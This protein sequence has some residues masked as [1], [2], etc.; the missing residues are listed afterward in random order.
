MKPAFLTP[1][2]AV[3]AG[4]SLAAGAH[5]QVLMLD[6][7]PTTTTATGNSPYHA[8][9]PG[10]TGTSWNKVQTSDLGSGLVFAD[11]SAASGVSVN[12]GASTSVTTLDLSGVPS[13]NSALGSTVNTGIYAGTSVGTDGIFTGSTNL[14]GTSVGVQIGGLAAGTYD[15]YIAARNTS[16]ASTSNYSQA[17]AVGVSSVSGNFNYSGYDSRTLSFTNAASPIAT[18]AWADGSN[19]L[20]FSVTLSSDQFL[21]LAVHG[22]GEDMRGFLNAV[23]IVATSSAIPEPSSV[24][25][26]GGAAVLGVAALRRRRN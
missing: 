26:L 19:Y 13:G 4:L 23:Q 10:F 21:N 9:T 22:G 3:A 7:G 5:S 18:S 25:V 20:K 1:L 6:F 14:T 11:G 24:A 15:V 17:V 8:A 12:V 16:R 2:I